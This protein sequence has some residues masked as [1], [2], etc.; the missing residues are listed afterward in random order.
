MVKMPFHIS[1]LWTRIL[2]ITGVLIF[3]ACLGRTD[4]PD[5]RGVEIDPAHMQWFVRI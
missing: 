5:I 4:I 2:G 3:I 1:R